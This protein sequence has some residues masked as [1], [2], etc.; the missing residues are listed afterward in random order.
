MHLKRQKDMSKQKTACNRSDMTHRMGKRAQ[1][2]TNRF[3]EIEQ[4]LKDVKTNGS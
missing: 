1:V 4:E 3:C 2:T